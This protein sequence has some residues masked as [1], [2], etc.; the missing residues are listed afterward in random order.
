MERKLLLQKGTEG[1]WPNLIRASQD[2]SAPWESQGVTLSA[3]GLPLCPRGAT[4][5]LS[6]ESLAQEVEESGEVEGAS[7]LGHLSL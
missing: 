1:G 6:S 4:A 3:L 2:A 7:V 5:T